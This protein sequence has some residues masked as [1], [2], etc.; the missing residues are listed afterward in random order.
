MY[1]AVMTE[2]L[3]NIFQDDLDLLTLFMCVRETGTVNVT[4]QL[5][6]R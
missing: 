1:K 6:V 2:N 4:T 5:N 3:G